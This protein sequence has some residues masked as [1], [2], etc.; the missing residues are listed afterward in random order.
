LFILRDEGLPPSQG[1]ARL[2]AHDITSRLADNSQCRSRIAD[3]ANNKVKCGDALLLSLSI[4]RGTSTT[5]Y[6]LPT[7]CYLIERT[8]LNQDGIPRLKMLKN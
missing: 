7:C 5:S 3:E 6:Q 8:T 1:E 2:A 4:P